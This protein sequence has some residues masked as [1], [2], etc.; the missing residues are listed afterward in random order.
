MTTP[1]HSQSA[2]QSKWQIAIDQPNYPGNTVAGV[3]DIAQSLRIIL[4]TPLGSNPLRPLFGCNMLAYLDQPEN[5]AVPNLMRETSR[6]IALWEPRIMLE[7]VLPARRADG[8]WVLTLQWRFKQGTQSHTS[9]V[10]YAA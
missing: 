6:A 4:N 10:V 9:E 8:H 2:A 1:N 7:R 5:I 3:D